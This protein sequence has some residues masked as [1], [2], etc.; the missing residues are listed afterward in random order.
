MLA[1]GVGSTQRQS[2]MHAFYFDMR[3]RCRFSA[4]HP[5]MWPRS[6]ASDG[7]ICSGGPSSSSSIAMA[8]SAAAGAAAAASAAA[9]RQLM[10]AVAWLGVLVRLACVHAPAAGGCFSSRTQWRVDGAVDA[11]AQLL[12]ARGRRLLH[13]AGM[14]ACVC[15]A[16]HARQR[17]LLQTLLAQHTHTRKC[18]SSI[19]SAAPLHCAAAGLTKTAHHGQPVP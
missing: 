14:H 4:A 6:S 18:S 16:A 13:P 1:W 7:T 11:L 10:P 17:L 12:V 8:T 2:H 3:A 9:S 15:V 5:D 19:C